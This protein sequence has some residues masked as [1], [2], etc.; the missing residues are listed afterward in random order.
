VT[1]AD[2]IALAH[3][4]LTQ[5]GGGERVALAM[6]AAFPGAPLHTSVYDPAATFAGFRDVPVRT[7]WLQ[8]VPFVGPDPR[9]ALALL[10][11]AWN[12]M[13]VD[14][15]T[16]A[17]LCS[18]AG[19]AH[20]ITTPDGCRKIV[21]CHNPARWLYQPRDYLRSRAARAAFAPWR[22]WLTA[23]D[24]RM[25]GTATAY[26]ANS[27]QVARRVRAA[28]GIDAEVLH[29][30]VMVDA[31]GERTA[32][33]GLEPGFWLAVA[34]GRGYKNVEVLTAAMELLPGERLV[35]VG[36]GPPPG[37]HRSPAV[38]FTG[39]VDEAR[40]RWLYAHARGLVGVAVED[41][42]LAPLEA[43][44]F[45]TPVAVIRAGGYLESTQEGVSGVFI[46][47]AS[48]PAVARALRS[49]PDFDR[50]RVV[51]NARRFDAD[52]FAERLRAVVQHAVAG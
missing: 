52:R 3:D 12:A 40:L 17:V 43:N 45:G 31:T 7:S 42:G 38:R 1:T 28:Y 18:S 20:G 46:D 50:G 37:A 26:L 24:R 36:H 34:R 32:V 27:A 2:G 51:A 4:Y 19:W 10:P 33:P 9:R 25:A 22:R 6:A 49:F 13:R 15:G 41:F 48:P 39:R 23:W 5:R 35:V 44:A 21:Y 47:E 8:G 14:E 30:P 16:R 11:R 29:P